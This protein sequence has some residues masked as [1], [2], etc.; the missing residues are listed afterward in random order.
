MSGTGGFQTQAYNQPVMGIAG[1][2]A[3]G[4]PYFTLDAGPGGLVAGSGGLTVGRFAWIYPPLDPDGTPALALNSGSG[5]VS[6]FVHR[7][8]QASITNYLADAS[9]VVLQGQP[10]T[11]MVGGDFWVVNDGSGQATIGQKAFANL[12]TGKVS[13]AAAGTYP[14]SASDSGGAVVNTTLTLVG[15]VAGNILTVTSVSA[16]TIYPGAVLNSNAVGQVQP[17]GTGGTTGTGTTGTYMLSVGE[18]TVA[19]GTTIGGNYGVYTVG[20]ATGTFTVGMLLSGGTTLLTGASS[21][22]LTYLISGT[23]GSAS[24]FAT[25]S[26]TQAQT[27]HALVGSTVIET[28]WY[29]MSSGL[30]GELVKISDHATG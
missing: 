10:V 6:G 25:N 5:P 19:A 28:K 14:S 23:G 3:S 16:G 20:T 27:T 12:L 26:G 7:A 21:P 13:F 15:S 17:Y 29:C 4:N 11:L 8:Q 18:Q 24:T 1:D 30:N 9:M 2:F 22:V